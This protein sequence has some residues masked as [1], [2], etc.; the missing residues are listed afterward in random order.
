MDRRSF[1]KW[2]THGLGALFAA[3]IG[4]PA[5]A[6]L[7]DARN[8]PARQGAFKTVGKLS[9]LTAGVP[10]Q[11]VISDVRQDAWTLYP[12][13]VVGKVWLVRRESGQVDAFT[14]TCPHLGCSIN[15]DK[16]TQHF[17]C[18]CHGGTFDLNGKKV[19]QAGKANPA[20]RDMD[21]LEERSDPANPELLQ[22]KHQEFRQGEHEKVLKS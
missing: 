20:P 11:V 18:P 21:R 6:Y 15:F 9:E 12:S 4:A 3:L 22:V 16:E 13:D 14:A 8:R 10:K 7:I 1:L 17:V 5:I 2:A 19:E